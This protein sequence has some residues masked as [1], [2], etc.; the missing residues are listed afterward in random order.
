[1]TLMDVWCSSPHPEPTAC[2]CLREGARASSYLA[3][4]SLACSHSCNPPPKMVQELQ[5]V[6][7]ETRTYSP[8]FCTDCHNRFRP[9][10]L[11]LSFAVEQALLDA[12]NIA[13]A[14][15]QAE[16]RQYAPLLA[17]HYAQQVCLMSHHALLTHSCDN[18]LL[19][20]CLA[21][22]VLMQGMYWHLAE[23]SASVHSLLGAQLLLPWLKSG[24]LV[25]QDLY[26]F[27]RSPAMQE[28]R[29]VKSV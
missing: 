5:W 10:D 9:C 4:V 7:M 16:K 15:N 25:A 18:L 3:C 19:P 28:Q 2:V 6:L 20:T 22:P 26:L 24:E 29:H 1:M 13:R 21:L 27:T 17:P 12:I 8:I 23:T 11:L 14:I